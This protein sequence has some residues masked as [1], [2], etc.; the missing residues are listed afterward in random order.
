MNDICQLLSCVRYSTLL[1][2][3]G[4]IDGTYC[5]IH[6]YG[7][8]GTDTKQNTQANV[9]SFIT[10][11][12][13]QRVVLLPFAFLSGAGVTLSWG[14]A[15]SVLQLVTECIPSIELRKDIL[16]FASTSTEIKSNL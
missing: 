10:H 12:N 1:T 3:C 9:T 5:I 6:N 2:G 13:N 4:G 8:G 16:P 15:Y 14:C 7:H 11:C